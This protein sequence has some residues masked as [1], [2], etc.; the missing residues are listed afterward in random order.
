MLENRNL[1]R[2]LFALALLAAVIFLAAALFT[3][4]PADPPAK[5]VFPRHSQPANVCGHWGDDGQP[6][7]CSSCSVS[8]RTTCW[9]RWRR[10]TSSCSCAATPDDIWLRAVG[11]LLSLVR[12]DDPGCPG[13]SHFRRARSSAPAD[14]SASS[15]RQSSQTHFAPWSAR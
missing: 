2:D 9:F 13:R 11:W 5:L 15:V 8:G 14:T 7:D 12:D 4:D 6:R 10:S 3:Y 1:K